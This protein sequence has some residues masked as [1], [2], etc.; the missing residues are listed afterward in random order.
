MLPC[1]RAA[2]DPRMAQF[3]SELLVM[4]INTEMNGLADV[5][6]LA[7]LS[8]SMPHKIKRPHPH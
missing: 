3:Q 7:C 4:Q 8:A 2:P 5:N 1:P 6:G